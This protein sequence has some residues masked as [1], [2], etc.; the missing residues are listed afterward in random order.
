MNVRVL[1]SS[2][3]RYRGNLLCYLFDTF[4]LKLYLNLYVALKQKVDSVL[5][6]APKI[7]VVSSVH[8]EAMCEANGQSLDSPGPPK[9]SKP[10][11][12]RVAF[13]RDA[14]LLTRSYERISLY[15]NKT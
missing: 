1:L 15:N 2:L 4:L 14:R 5:C 8:V 10:A 7:Y 6:L 9:Y 13:Y 3:A 12:F 11:C